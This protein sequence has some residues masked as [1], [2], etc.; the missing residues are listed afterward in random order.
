VIRKKNR[1]GTSTTYKAA[2]KETFLCPTFL[3]RPVL[4]VLG[5]NNKPKIRM[6][7]RVSRRLID[8]LPK[9]EEDMEFH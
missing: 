5:V 8:R 6:I 7:S 1:G 4:V 2:I 3:E 9:R